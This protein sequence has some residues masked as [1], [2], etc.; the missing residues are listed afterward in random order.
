MKK[1]IL[2][3]QFRNDKSLTHERSCLISK[4]GFDKSDLHFVNV[5]NSRIRIPNT[6]EL[7]NYRGII[8]GGSGEVN[9]SD[10]KKEIKNKIEA[11]KPLVKQAIAQDIPMLNICFGHQLVAHLLGGKVEADARQAETGTS[12]VHLI[13]KGLKSPLFKDVP[14]SFWAV[15]GH[16][17]SVAK[18]PSSAKILA[19]SDKC[20]I[21]AYQIKDNIFSVQF[22]PELD[23]AGIKFRLN[24]FPDYASREDHEK[25]LKHYRPTPYAYKIIE[26]FKNI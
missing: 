8:L 1:K 15:V 13:K 21:H 20:R 3:L 10:W 6:K 9:I 22:H 16:K 25:I 24:L 12:L 26:N 14:K 18:L 2:V 4:N 23:K 17:D 5:L 11:I 7:N 19:H